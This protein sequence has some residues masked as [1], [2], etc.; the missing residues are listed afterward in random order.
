MTSKRKSSRKRLEK[1]EMEPEMS[2]AGTGVTGPK[3][4]TT[5]GRQEQSG[6]A[7]G[8]GVSGRRREYSTCQPGVVGRRKAGDGN[9]PRL[10]WRGSATD[11][12]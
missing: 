12:G 4:K 3:V 9:P 5:A 2:E 7:P 6:G 10:W 11:R 8:P 1:G